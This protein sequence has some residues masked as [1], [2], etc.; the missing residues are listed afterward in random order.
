LLHGTTPC[1][2]P[3]VTGGDVYGASGQLGCADDWSYMPPAPLQPSCTGAATV[4]STNTVV[5]NYAGTCPPGFTAQW[6]KLAWNSYV[7]FDASGTTE[8]K[9]EVQTAPAIGGPYTAYVAAGDAMNPS[10]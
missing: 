6:D 2:A 10:P 8:I 9:F 3:G 4:F 5:E 1:S 7:P